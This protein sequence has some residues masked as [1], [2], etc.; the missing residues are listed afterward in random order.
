MFKPELS[1]KDKKRF[2]DK[3]EIR[4]ENECWEWVASKRGGYGQFGLNY[5]PVGAHRISYVLD[6]N[7]G[8]PVN[9]VVMHLC[10]N[11]SC[12]NPK[13]LKIGT[14][15]DNMVDCSEKGRSFR[16]SVRKI[17]KEQLFKILEL[18]E[19]NYERCEIAEKVG[20]EEHIIDGIL[21]AGNYRDWV[22]EWEEVN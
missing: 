19:S 3:V 14:Q 10:D 7:K 22:E 15:K 1:D 6:R 21:D 9:R 16:H 17:N 4:G 18:L 2:W 11:R 5:T 13:H 12:V 20:I 8:I